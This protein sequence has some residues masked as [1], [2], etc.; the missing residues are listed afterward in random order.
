MSK[1]YGSIVAMTPHEFV[2][3]ENEKK[4]LKEVREEKRRE[5]E[6]H[7]ARVNLFKSMTA[8]I[9]ANTKMIE[10]QL[11]ILDLACDLLRNKDGDGLKLLADT[12]DA[13]NSSNPYDDEDDDFDDFPEEI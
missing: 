9:D 12:L 1:A 7:G 10:T 13:V 3:R 11:K 2:Y 8:K 5:E 4:Y 6:L